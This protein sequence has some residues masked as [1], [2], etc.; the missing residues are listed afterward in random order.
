MSKASAVRR[1]PLHAVGIGLLVFGAGLQSAAAQTEDAPPARFEGAVGLILHL[2]PEYSGG[3]HYKLSGLPAVFLRYGRW[4]V[5]NSGAFA[6]RRQDDVLQGLGADLQRSDTWRTSLG[7]RIDRGRSSSASAALNGLDDVRSTIRLRLGSTWTPGGDHPL[8][9]WRFSAAAT[10][11]LLGRGGGS[12]LEFGISRDHRWSERIVWTNGVSLS[13][14]DARYMQSRYGITAA[15]AARTTYPEYTPGSGL[16]DAGV[17]TG[18]RMEINREWAALWGV[19][20]G[21]LLGPAA[22]S[23]LTARASHWEARGGLAWRF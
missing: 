18:W 9:P 21:R 1:L 23:P 4:T 16:L 8:H 19:S 5:S 6:T 13:A 2:A 10:T 20:A 7:L 22:S 12:T 11:D 17:S 14:A 15:E 3:A